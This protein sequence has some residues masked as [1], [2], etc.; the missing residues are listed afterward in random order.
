MNEMNLNEM[1]QVT[2]GA[3]HQVQT[4]VRGLDA[5]VRAEAK[6]SSRQIGHIP[7][8]VMVNT[9][10]DTLVYDPESERHY[11]EIY[12]NGGTGW[13]ASSILGLRR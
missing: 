6:K 9:V 1:E 3:N 5:A 2:G 12:F 11:V 10:S 4:G 13:V 8:G 7:N